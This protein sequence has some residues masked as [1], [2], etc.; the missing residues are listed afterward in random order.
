[1]ITAGLRVSVVIPVYNE[2]GMIRECLD[3]ILGQTVAADEV[4]VVA[5][6]PA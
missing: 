1:M 6:L 2:E 5:C 4:I 3:A